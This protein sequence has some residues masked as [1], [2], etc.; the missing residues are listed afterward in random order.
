MYQGTLH[1]KLVCRGTTRIWPPGL[2][3][4]E[5]LERPVGSTG[6]GG[7]DD[8]GAVLPA[9]RPRFLHLIRDLAGGGTVAEAA[10]PVLERRATVRGIVVPGVERGASWVSGT[11]TPPARSKAT[12]RPTGLCRL[13]HGRRADHACCVPIGK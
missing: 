6:S 5:D 1:A 12:Y 2:G 9:R 8:R 7:A 13:R 11:A 4:V 10:T 3:T